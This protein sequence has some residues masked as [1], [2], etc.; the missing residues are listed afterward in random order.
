MAW[1]PLRS[2]FFHSPLRLGGVEPLL[3][4]P[5]LKFGPQVWL[6]LLSASWVLVSS[7]LMLSTGPPLCLC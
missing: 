1:K 2:S 6:Q 4:L 7:L 3:L 5:A